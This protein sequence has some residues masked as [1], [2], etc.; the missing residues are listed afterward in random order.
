MNAHETLARE[1]SRILDYLRLQL[2]GPWDGE[3][4]TLHDLP[5]ARYLM[6]ILYP[7]DLSTEEMLSFAY[8]FEDI[9]YFAHS[10]SLKK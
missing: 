8:R 9:A 1:R 10:F 3:R 5:T 4:E 2:I 6:G 7:Q